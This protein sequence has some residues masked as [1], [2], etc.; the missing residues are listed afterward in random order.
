MGYNNKEMY[1]KSVNEIEPA[2]IDAINKRFAGKVEAYKPED[3]DPR[4][5]KNNEDYLRHR[6]V[7]INIFETCKT[8]YYDVKIQTPGRTK[9]FSIADTLHGIDTIDG[10][11]FVI[12]RTAYVCNYDDVM[13]NLTAKLYHTQNY[14]LISVYNILKISKYSFEI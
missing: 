6:D 5:G 14:S 8:K 12:N 4:T 7:A 1:D 9:N 2:V 11:I 3:I 10:F 13:N